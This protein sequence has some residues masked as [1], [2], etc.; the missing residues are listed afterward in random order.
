[1]YTII[2][3]FIFLFGLIIGS[4]LNVV[5]YRLNTGKSIARGR[6]MCMT[7]SHT[8]SWYELLP[9]FSFLFQRGK[10][11][12]CKSKISTQYIIVEILTGI[13]FVMIANVFIDVMYFKQFIL[14][15]LLPAFLF[16]LLIVI[17]VYDLRHKIIPNNIVYI[18]I[19]S[20][21]ISSLFMNFLFTHVF[22]F[23]ILSTLVSGIVIALPFA[24]I[25]FASRGRAMG[26]GDAKLM[27]GIGFFLGIPLSIGATI[28]AF[29]AGALVG[30]FLI[31][32]SR[33][34]VGMKSEIPFGPFLILGAFLAFVFRI[35]FGFIVSL[36]M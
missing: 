2:F 3:V 25:W 18:F 17:A 24:L 28:L 4:F 19:C 32:K 30:I 15:F 12:S 13:V 22:L 1:M 10:C 8:L 7:C 29:W 11:K 34:K 27:L 16:S 20:A 33:G 9:V 5:I 26:F 35:D 21:F 6:S 36:F 23:S 31:I 14:M